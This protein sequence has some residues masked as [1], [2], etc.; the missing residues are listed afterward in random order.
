MNEQP[1]PT[2]DLLTPADVAAVLFVDPK[3]VTRWATAGKINALRTPGG[4]RRFLRS[5]VMTLVDTLHR[6]PA[7]RAVPRLASTAPGSSAAAAAAVI[8]DAV[9][10]AL[11]ADAESAARAARTSALALDRAQAEAAEAAARARDARLLATAFAAH[12]ASS[13]P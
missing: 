11:E 9:A 7:Q 13:G 6:D 2:I 8:A 1:D 4:H 5:D 10:I 12:A 3:T